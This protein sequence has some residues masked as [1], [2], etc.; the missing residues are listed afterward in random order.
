MPQPA[1]LTAPVMSSATGFHRNE[2]R[3]LGREE[4]QHLVAAQPPPERD[5]AGIVRPVMP[6]SVSAAW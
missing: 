3:G 4:L 6:A 5:M 1:D 2:A